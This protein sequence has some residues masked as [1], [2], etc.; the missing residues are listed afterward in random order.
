M[1]KQGALNEKY[2]DKVKEEFIS[3]F[4][5]MKTNKRQEAAAI[6]LLVA[7]SILLEALDEISQHVQRYKYNNERR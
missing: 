2:F 7:Y 1:S 4:I 3:A 5:T 6:D